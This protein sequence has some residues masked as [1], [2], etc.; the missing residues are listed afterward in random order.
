M[1]IRNKGRKIINFGQISVLPGETATIPDTFNANET[2]E[3]LKAL[4]YIEVIESKSAGKGKNV[5]G[6]FDKGK[7]PD[8][9]SETPDTGEGTPADNDGAKE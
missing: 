1:V 8:K 4:G 6:K 5:G 2:L 7:I 9:G 3:T